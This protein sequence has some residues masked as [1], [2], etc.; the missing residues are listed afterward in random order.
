MKVVE[1]EQPEKMME[2]YFVGD[3]HYPRGIR[4]KF[5]EVLKQIEDNP[6]AYVIGMGD[7][8]ENITAGDPRYNPEEMAS[9]IMKHGQPLNMVDAQWKMFEE[10]IKPLAEKKKILGLL[11]GNHGSSFTRRNSYNALKGICDRNDIK[12]LGDGMAVFDISYKGKHTYIQVFHG[13]GGGTT[14][15]FAYKRLSDY[16]NII[17]DVDVV[18]AGHCFDEE[19]ELLTKDGWKKH[20]EISVGDVALTYNLKTDNSEWNNIEDISHYTHYKKMIHFKNK[21]MNLMVTPDHSIVGSWRYLKTPFKRLKAKDYV[22]KRIDM[23]NG[24]KNINE[25]YTKYTDDE[26]KLIAWVITEGCYEDGSHIRIS[27]SNKPKVG[28]KRIEDLCK[29]MNIE[30]YL[31]ERSSNENRNYDAFRIGLRGKNEFVKMAMKEFPDKQLTNEFLKLSERQFKILFEELMLGDGIKYGKRMYQYSTKYEKE[32]DILQSLCAYNGYRSSKISKQDKRWHKS[33]LYV[34]S[35]NTRGVTSVSENSGK[36]VDYNGVAWCPTVKNE[37]VVVRRKGK[38]IVSG[39]S[40]RLGVNISI[41]PLKLQ[42]GKLKQRIQYHCST[43]SFLGNYEEDTTSYAERKA[44]PPLPI[45]YV[46]MEIYKGEV[47]PDSVVPVPV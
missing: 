35:I 16:S 9:I 15:G 22:N 2:L 37:T 28:M 13:S 1:F 26:L 14:V 19:T 36:Y 39:N 5:L 11:M 41:R 42:D 43:G 7:F 38:T 46:R 23:P 32:A 27:Q 8:C 24:G 40:H 30:Y 3:V 10:D 4:S 29:K 45:G 18:A 33:I 31:S 17:S 21:S 47:V 6:N 34:I 44:Y 12:Y 25:E 20:D